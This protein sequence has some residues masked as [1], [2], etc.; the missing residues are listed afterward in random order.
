[1]LR[2][3]HVCHLQGLQG[4]QPV[5]GGERGEAEGPA[6]AALVMRGVKKSEVMRGG[7]TRHVWGWSL[8]VQA[9][10]RHAGEEDLPLCAVCHLS[11]LG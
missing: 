11:L 6:Q 3:A 5:H 4:G 9:W 1:M 10:G 8:E 2:A 7:I